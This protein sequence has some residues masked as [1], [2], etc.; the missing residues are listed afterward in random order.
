MAEVATVLFFVGPVVLLLC[1]VLAQL[2]GSGAIQRNA[3]IGIRTRATL[4]S[5]GAWKAGHAAAR[6]PALFAVVVLVVAGIAAFLVPAPSGWTGLGGV[7]YTVLLMGF[8]VWLVVAAD[9]AA[10][11]AD[12]IEFSDA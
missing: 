12:S 7:A 2:A 8:V 9:R 4:S 6:G 1:F 3:T 5:D 11:G 10:R